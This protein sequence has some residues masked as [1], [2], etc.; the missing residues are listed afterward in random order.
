MSCHSRQAT[1]VE[2]ARYEPF[3]RTVNDVLD[4]LRDLNVPEGHFNPSNPSV[5]LFSRNAEKIIHST[6]DSSSG[7]PLKTERKPDVILTPI[8]AASR[9]YGIESPAAKVYETATQQPPNAFTW[10]DILSFVEFKLYSHV[11]PSALPSEYD[12]TFR[13][14]Y[15]TIEDN[16]WCLG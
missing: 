5:V 10:H 8:H 16:Y 15:S 11:A 12:I 6:Y 4:Q 2:S 1:A 14:R 3:V 7:V 13:E 9:Y